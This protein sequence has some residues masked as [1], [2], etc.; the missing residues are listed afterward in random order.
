MED[1]IK[2]ISSYNL[3]NYLFPGIVFVVLADTIT[4][5]NFAQ[6]DILLAIFI[7]Y[8]IG[9]SVSRF[10]SLIIE[11]LLK[12]I[13]FIEFADYTKEYLPAIKKD[14]SIE[15]LSEI[16]NVYRTISSVFVLLVILKIYS[17]LENKFLFLHEFGIY[18]LGILLLIMF[19]YSYK[20]QTKYVKDKV[21]YTLGKEEN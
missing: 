13:S 8:F 19:F 16:N 12:K 14:S 15:I 7:Y 1:L 21:L 17:L 11:P 3:F 10:G 9:L 6:D 20:K 5:Y 4:P 18:I 2:K